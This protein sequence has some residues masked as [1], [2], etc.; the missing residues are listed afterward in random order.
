MPRLANDRHETYALLRA[1]GM[2][3]PQAAQGAGFVAG[4]AV[5]SELEKDPEIKARAQELLD[6]NNL[7]RDQM[8][9]AAHEAAKVVGQMSGVS[10]SWVLQKLAEN[11]QMAAQDG[12]YK[13]SNAALKLIGDEFGMFTGASGEGSDQGDGKRSYDLDTMSALLDKAAETLPTPA[14]KVDPNVAFDLIAGQGEAAKRARQSRAFSDGEEAD[15]AFTEAA[16]IDAVPDGPWSGPAPED[17][18]SEDE[19]EAMVGESFEKID[20][21]T[22]PE[23]IMARIAQ[24]DQSP[25]SSDDRPKRRS[26]R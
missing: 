9:T 1:K 12:D 2:K 24:A 23:E 16:D 19:P 4:S 21:Q 17:F 22:S 14:P 10:K 7:K 26:S 8:R 11:A 18:F 6:E 5:Y 20:P 25:T 15:M 3:P 13:E